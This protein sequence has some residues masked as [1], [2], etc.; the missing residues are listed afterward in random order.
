MAGQ[1]IRNLRMDTTTEDALWK[2]EVWIDGVIVAGSF[3]TGLEGDGIYFT[4][5]E[6]YEIHVIRNNYQSR[7]TCKR[8]EMLERLNKINF[9]R[10]INKYLPA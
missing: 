6:P 7:S 4:V 9:A 8:D 1:E 3:D 5:W 10:E 2:W